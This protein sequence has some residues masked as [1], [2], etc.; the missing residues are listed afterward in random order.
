MVFRKLKLASSIAGLS[1]TL[2]AN[3]P[4]NAGVINIDFTSDAATKIIGAS[5]TTEPGASP[6]AHDWVNSTATG[7]TAKFGV[8]MVPFGQTGT[9]DVTAARSAVVYNGSTPQ[10]MRMTRWNG[11]G[12]AIC[13]EIPDCSSDE[14][15]GNG[16]DAH[17]VDGKGY[18]TGSWS[19]TVYH[20]INESIGFSFS[21]GLDFAVRYVTFGY[22][23]SND[24][25]R[26][27]FDASM[28][29]FVDIDLDYHHLSS[30]TDYSSCSNLTSSS[31]AT[32]TIDLY[33][34]VS[35]PGN[36]AGL[37]YDAAFDAAGGYAD[38]QG[39]IFDHLSSPAGFKFAALDS[40]DNWKIRSIGLVTIPEP[41]S[42]TML[43]G[44]LLVLAYFTR[45]RKVA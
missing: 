12:L 23:D 16:I 24:H 9:L 40:D 45:R 41:A 22:S 17:T 11:N 20:D 5:S 35:A 26:M 1:L 31:Q 37:T 38:G 34:L 27:F 4:A 36:L 30:N 6:A 2:F 28:S 10:A 8:D 33:K 19:S 42:M 7:L 39:A 32:C 13:S 14:L 21:N 18:N 15:P 44:G 3:A 25:A 29:S 43:G